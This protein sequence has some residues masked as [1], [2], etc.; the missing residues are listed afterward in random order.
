M[1]ELTAPVKPLGDE[2]QTGSAVEA[3]PEEAQPAPAIA[4]EEV[5]AEAETGAEEEAPAWTSVKDREGLREHVQPFL[6]EAERKG[7][8]HRSEEFDKYAQPYLQQQSQRINDLNAG[9]GRL[10]KGLDG[11]NKAVKE[12]VLDTDTFTEW[13]EA[14]DHTFKAMAGLMQKPWEFNGAK[15]LMVTLADAAGDQTLAQPFM[16]RLDVLASGVPDPNL[17]HDLIKKL[18]SKASADAKKP[19]E[20]KIARLEAQIE[21]R[22]V[23]GRREEGPNLTPGVGAGGRSDAELLADPN[24]PIEKLKEIRARQKAG[25]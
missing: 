5:T 14:H 9:L 19:L 15:R 20:D 22:K 18:S 24:T 17:F 7:Y 3:T 6:E 13:T 21:Q 16:R 23:E 8:E 25:R 12:G 2:L 11:L 4:P 10:L 1:Q